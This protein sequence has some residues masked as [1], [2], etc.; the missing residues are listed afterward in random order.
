MTEQEAAE[1]V[2]RGDK[3]ERCKDCLDKPINTNVP[4]VSC[5]GARVMVDPDYAQACQILGLPGPR[6][7]TAVDAPRVGMRVREPSRKTLLSEEKGWTY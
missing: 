5:S 6:R 3:Y 2:L 4:C 7:P 1:V